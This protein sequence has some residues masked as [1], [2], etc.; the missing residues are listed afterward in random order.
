MGSIGFALFVVLTVVGPVLGAPPKLR[1]A[2]VTPR[3]ATTT[4]TVVF[5]VSY[6]RMSF[7]AYVRVRVGTRAY[8]MS[9]QG[10]GEWRS[11]GR[12]RNAGRMPAGIHAVVF[13]GSS[14]RD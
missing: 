13:E 5:E 9:W 4:T 12:F 10:S 14:V 2:T 7:P 11:G 3:A 1:D 8:T 6:D